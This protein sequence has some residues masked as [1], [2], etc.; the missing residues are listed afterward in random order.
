MVCEFDLCCIAIG[1]IWMCTQ[2]PCFRRNKYIVDVEK[3]FQ[4]NVLAWRTMHKSNFSLAK[5]A[6]NSWLPYHT[7]NSA[8]TAWD[9]FEFIIL[10]FWWWWC[11]IKVIF[12]NPKGHA[13]NSL[14]P[15]FLCLQVSS[16][17][18]RC[19]LMWM[20][21]ISNKEKERKDCVGN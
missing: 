21:M 2:D 14:H 17:L 7:P 13:C 19:W 12:Q 18:H 6:N 16:W 10:F 9:L 5:M 20:W 15:D 1:K 11:V 4:L 3:T 8:V